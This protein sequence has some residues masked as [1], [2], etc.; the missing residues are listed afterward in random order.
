M[1]DV[2]LACPAC[3]YV[4][5]E[6]QIEPGAWWAEGSSPAAIAKRPWCPKCQQAP[7]MKL[8]S[9]P[10]PLLRESA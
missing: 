1:T 6:A 7:P 3:R 5:L 4:W 2:Y 10:L 8:V 9:V